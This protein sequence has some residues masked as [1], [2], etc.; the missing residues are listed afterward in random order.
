M[1]MA[2]RLSTLPGN[3]GCVPT[4]DPSPA[5]Q[6]G[7]IPAVGPLH[8]PY[9]SRSWLPFPYA[10]VRPGDS[11][12]KLP[13]SPLRRPIGRGILFCLDKD[14]WQ[15][16]IGVSDTLTLGVL[17][18]SEGSPRIVIRLPEET[19]D[20]IRDII[21]RLNRSTTRKPYTVSSWIRKAIMA[22]VAHLDRSEG[23]KKI[24]V[25]TVRLEEIE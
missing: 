19:L 4:G 9:K 3:S 15:I 12:G 23:T 11:A 8:F 6:P 24:D 10:G 21:A 22:E 13:G 20:R 2:G 14:T 17:P 18:M 1:S 7:T 5:L 25:V 16:T